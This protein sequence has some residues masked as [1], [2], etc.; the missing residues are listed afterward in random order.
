MGE[1]RAVQQREVW[2]SENSVGNDLR[3]LQNPLDC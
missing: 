1:E 2:V 3:V